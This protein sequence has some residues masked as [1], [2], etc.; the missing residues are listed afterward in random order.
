MKKYLILFAELGLAAIFIL[1]FWWNGWLV[2]GAQLL[3]PHKPLDKGEY[4][5]ISRS[6]QPQEITIQNQNSQTT[7][8]V[9][10]R[11]FVSFSLSEKTSLLVPPKVL[12]FSANSVVIHSAM[13]GVIILLVIVFAYWIKRTQGLS[14]SIRFLLFAFVFG[15][16]GS[17]S[18]FFLMLSVVFGLP[19]AIKEYRFQWHHALVIVFF[20]WAVLSGILSRF[21]SYGVGAAFLFFLYV[22]IAFSFRAQR[23]ASLPWSMIGKS[24]LFAFFT[25]SFV[26]LIQQWYIKQHVGIYTHQ[27]WVLFWP[28]HDLELVSLFEWAARGGYWL[29]LMIPLL[30]SIALREKEKNA[31]IL[32]TIGVAVGLLLLLFT[33]S[34]GGFVIAF[35]GIVS[36][37]LFLKRGYIALLLALLPLAFVIVA[38]NSKWSQSLKNPFSFHTNV[39]RLHQIQAGLDFFKD[40]HP[41]TGIGLMNFKPYYYEKRHT[42]DIYSMADYLHQGFIAILVETGIVGFILLYGF[43]IVFWIRML[44][45]SLRK[46]PYAPLILAILNGMWVSLLFDA[47]LW[48]AFYLGMWI[49]M[50]IGLGENLTE[51]N[52]TPS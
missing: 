44:L 27:H 39:Q 32:A 50:W 34:R 6:Y 4:I 41:L 28:Y 33:Q 43:L 52:T 16:S 30:T 21:P 9:G 31:K 17:L 47:M 11:Q 40:S 35:V 19:A 14:W 1:S 51:N 45:L 3:D 10:G 26:G 22:L 23:P 24:L 49:W 25:V 12:I 36:Q 48:Y 20:L 5:A 13:I 2:V 15:W 42:Y 29:G 46:Q 8:T 38:P 37:L 18:V 7:I